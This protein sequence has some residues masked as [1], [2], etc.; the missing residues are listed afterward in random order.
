M[1][2]TYKQILVLFLF[3]TIFN[4]SAQ[5]KREFDVQNARE[6]ESVEY[7]FTHKKM[8][9]LM[10]NQD[11]LIQKNKE[12]LEFDKLVK[13]G[14]V[15]KGTV[16]KI[17]VVFHVLH[18]SGIENISDEQIY[19]ALATLNRDFRK[20]NPDTANVHVEFTGMPFDSEIEFVL[21]TKAPDGT[22]F[23]GITRT[24]TVLTFQGEDG[25]LQAQAVRDGNDVYIGDWPGNKYLNFFISSDI[26]GAAGYTHYPSQGSADDMTNGIWLLHD[27]VGSIGT[28]SL[29]HS[30]V[31]THEC[32]HWLN[33]PHT[34]GSTN[35]P[36]I[37]SNCDSDDG[38]S[39]TPNCIGVTGCA[40]N[41]NSCDSDNAFWGFDIRDNV[42]NYMEYSYCCKMF[43]AGQGARMR[44]AVQQTN[45]GRANLWSQANLLATGANGF[46]YLCKAEFSADKEDICLGE[47][48]QFSDD[49]YNS[50]TNWQWEISPNFGWSFVPG[51]SNTSQNPLIL[52]SQSGL[53]SVKLTASDGTNTLQELKQNFIRVAPEA[54]VL[55]FW[56]GF[57]DYISL[58][59]LT[60]WGVNNFNNN[61]AF[62]IENA[63]SYSGNKCA[64]LKN[65]GEDTLSIDELI[66]STIDLSVIP[67][68]DTVT[69]SF[70]FSY[71]KRQLSD[72]EFL[73]VFISS[74]CGGT[75]HQRKTLSNN[76]LSPFA[77][78]TNWMPT[79]QS[80]WTTVHM[81]NVTSTYF[82]NNFKMK[83]RFEG[84]GGNNLYIDDINLYAGL[85]SN[86]LVLGKQELSQI[87]EIIL[88]PNPTDDELQIE[89]SI[90]NS[91]GVQFS[92]VDLNG[93]VLS[94]HTIKAVAGKNT[95]LI[96]V[97]SLASGSYFVKFGNENSTNA[98]K[99]I[100]K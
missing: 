45:T 28:S 32:G 7:C 43:T 69:L 41:S 37:E 78:S 75:W 59:N 33:L 83:F 17:P 99:F 54:H 70:R 31:L 66:S 39:D 94:R 58:Q 9:A 13:K 72:Y 4:L 92:I 12:D 15:N 81:T 79:Q 25:D 30:R 100:V 61:Q 5:S 77:V 85:P 27:Y 11:F 3:F 68:T 74:N 76:N 91:E 26:G 98:L 8:Q 1:K 19:D 64:T 52:F 97:S 56:E 34:W 14:S 10:Q 50:V 89:F 62:T 65:F 18:Y 93:K 22:C 38:V 2:F 16:Y 63:T 82:T 23:K 88:F 71:R 86:D 51:S 47:Q 95:V 35:N 57:E 24:E 29:S 84:N 42:E 96:P 90:A 60:N 87:S 55:P 73:K 44:T 48:I 49:S 20:Q 6:G 53:Y 46:L 67:P 40:L 80:D 21:A 36:G